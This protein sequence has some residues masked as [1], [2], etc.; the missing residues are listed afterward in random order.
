VQVAVVENAAAGRYLKGALL[1]LFRALD[2]GLVLDDLEHEEAR[3]DG[4]GPEQEKETDDPK[5]RPL[6]GDDAGR[7]VAVVD[8]SNGCLHGKT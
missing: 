8:G 7:I 4:A 6:Q 5:A 2:I 1:L 3:G